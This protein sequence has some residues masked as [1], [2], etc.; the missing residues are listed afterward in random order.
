MQS[1]HQSLR[2]ISAAFGLLG[3]TFLSSTSFA[4]EE[5][6]FPGGIQIQQ[7]E[8][9]TP[10]RGSLESSESGLSLSVMSASKE[11]AEQAD[12]PLE[13]QMMEAVEVPEPS[14]MMAVA[15][16]AGCIVFLNHWRRRRDYR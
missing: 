8:V 16:G 13:P 14:F 10:E 7:T 9:D 4:I 2:S 15:A 3:A 6:S 5:A 1:S 12:E 11:E